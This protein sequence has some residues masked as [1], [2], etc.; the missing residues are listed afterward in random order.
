MTAGAAAP[1]RRQL[2]H[3][4]RAAGSALGPE[5]AAKL[6]AGVLAAPPEIGTSWHALVANPTPPALAEAL[7]QLK[8]YLA[9]DYRDGVSTEDFKRLP[10][11][12]RPSRGRARALNRGLVVGYAPCLHPPQEVELSR[13]G[14]ERGGASLRPAEE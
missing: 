6:V 7:E 14:A 11:A 1:D 2:A 5:E 4:R 3:L 12:A 10:S 13:A 9:T 8:D